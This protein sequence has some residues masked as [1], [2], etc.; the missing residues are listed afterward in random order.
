VW[1]SKSW[2]KHTVIKRIADYVIMKH[3]SLENKDLIHVV[4]QLDFCLLVNGQGSFNSLYI[5]LYSIYLL[6][7]GL[8]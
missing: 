6:G 8:N 5:V 2:E 7:L 3:L 4:D 1:E